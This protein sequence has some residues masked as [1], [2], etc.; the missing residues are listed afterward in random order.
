MATPPW[1]CEAP[2]GRGRGASCKGGGPARSAEPASGMGLDSVGL[3]VVIC[4]AR[5]KGP[6]RETSPLSGLS[7]ALP[8]WRDAFTCT[9]SGAMACLPR[10]MLR[11]FLDAWQ[12]AL[13]P[14]AGNASK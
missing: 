11:F 9:W 1:A 8:R 3:V 7:E 6:K 4:F 5:Q 2:T 12:I 10:H 14:H 13:I